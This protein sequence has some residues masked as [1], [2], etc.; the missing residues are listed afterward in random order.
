[1]VCNLNNVYECL[2]NYLSSDINIVHDRTKHV[3]VLKARSEDAF[4]NGRCHCKVFF[5]FQRTYLY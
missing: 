2:L 1:M 4:C 5:E 3:I